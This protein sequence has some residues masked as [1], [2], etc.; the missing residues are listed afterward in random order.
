ML[1]R[2]MEATLAVTGEENSLIDQRSHYYMLQSSTPMQRHP[3]PT[4]TITH[5][6]PPDETEGSGNNDTEEP[7][8]SQAYEDTKTDNET[9]DG[10]STRS[11][12]PAKKRKVNEDENDQAAIGDFDASTFASPSKPNS[13]YDATAV[14]IS[15][16]EI[17]CIVDIK[18]FLYHFKAG[19]GSWWPGQLN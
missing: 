16:P 15:M 5:H 8:N 17:G 14:V 19:L 9:D 12:S 4:T 3:M 10:K 1:L 7:P 2:R 18:G 6:P 11:T 13:A